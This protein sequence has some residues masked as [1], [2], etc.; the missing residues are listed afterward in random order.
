VI[1]STGGGVRFQLADK[2]HIDLLCAVPVKPIEGSGSNAIPG[3]TV[4][5]NLT[6]GL[7]DLFNAIHRKIAAGGGK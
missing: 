4:L 7:N 5:L 2:L 1:V 3:P 6:V